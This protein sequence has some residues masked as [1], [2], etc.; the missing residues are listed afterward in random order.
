MT[1]LAVLCGFL[2]AGKTTFLRNLLPEVTALGLRPRVIINDY[3]NAN[4][5]AAELRQLATL[6][7]PVSGSCVCCGSREE[8]V[9]A[10]A[11]FDATPKQ[12]ALVEAN[13][14]TDT[15]A[16]LEILAGARE[17]ESLSPPLQLTVV[18]A[19]RFGARDWRNEL[20]RIQISTAT[21]LY[22][23]RQDAVTPARSAEVRAAAA[24]EAPRAAW[25]DPA[26]FAHALAAIER[27]IAGIPNRRR[28]VEDVT[29][30]SARFWAKHTPEQ[31]R[32]PGTKPGGEGKG[33]PRKTPHGHDDRFHFA[34]VELPLP[35]RVD[36]TAFVAFLRALPPEV[37]R[38]KGIVELTFPPGA[39]RSFQK[40][41]GE[42]EISDCELFEPET[43]ECTAVL[44]GARLPVEPIQAQLRVLL[45]A[46]SKDEGQDR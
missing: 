27:R 12:V 9:G 43:L 16:M 37:I 18:D 10:L 39:K 2:G 1:P 28:L 44:I 36:P 32:A 24:A 45:G 23:S 19:L 33:Q 4:V 21:H 13:G 41:E 5:D 17:L 14:T 35:G 31:R 30:P 15:E 29:A 40:V 11:A 20:E 42:A 22:L 46:V 7:E 3:Q 26:A 8:L 25:T 38:A 34:A 6:V